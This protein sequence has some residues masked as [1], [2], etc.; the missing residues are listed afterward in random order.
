MTKV[1]VQFDLAKPLDEPAMEAIANAHGYYGI[2][3]VRLQ[4]SMDSI[5]VEYDAS[6]LT[7]TDVEA[8]LHRAGIP[9]QRKFTHHVS[10]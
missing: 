3:Y 1:Q 10:V 9:V 5:F 8:T 6:R 2:L 4:P 7:D